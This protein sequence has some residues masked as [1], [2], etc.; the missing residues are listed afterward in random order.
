MSVSARARHSGFDDVVGDAAIET[1]AS[2]FGFIEGPVWHP[3]EKWLVFSDIP[4]SRMY[5]RSAVGRDRAVPRA[6]PQGQWQ[7][8]RP[9]G[10]AGHL[11]ACDEPGDPRRAEWQRDGAGHASSGQ[12]AQ[13][14]ERHR[15]CHRRIDLLHRSGLWPGGVLWRAAAAGAVVPGRLP[16]RR[17]RRPADTA[18]RRF[19]PAERSL[20]L[21][22]RVAAV[23]QRHRARAH[24]GVRRRSQWRSQ[25]RRGVGDDRGRRSRER[26]TA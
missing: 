12:A 10:A 20:L 23:H 21:A 18:G 1:L 15:R 22:G 13:Q 17:R 7:H 3:Y 24:Q 9:P 8:A 11:R 5:R 19:R 14:P 26:P 2:G 4:E 16:D 6:E 25:R